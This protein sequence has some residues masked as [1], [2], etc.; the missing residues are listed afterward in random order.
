M[1]TQS[2]CFDQMLAEL[3]ISMSLWDEIIDEII[4]NLLALHKC[5][6]TDLISKSNL[7]IP[8]NVKHAALI[9]QLTCCQENIQLE[10]INYDRHFVRKF[11]REQLGRQRRRKCKFK[12]ES[13]QLYLTMWN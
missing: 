8:S 2:A 4:P 6:T 5:H 3:G 9:I 1:I 12:E 13:R 7:R 10:E 11:W